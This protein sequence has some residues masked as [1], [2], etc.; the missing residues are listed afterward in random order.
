MAS[1]SVVSFLNRAKAATL[2]ASTEASGYDVENLTE[3][4]LIGLPWRS[5]VTTDSW[6][7]VDLGAAITVD[8][9]SLVG[10]NFTSVK[11]QQ[12]TSDSWGAPAY[13]SGTLTIGR[14]ADRRLYRISH[15]SA[16]LTRRYTR[17]FIPTQA[18]TDG[19]AYF[20]LAG[21]HLGSF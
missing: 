8:R 17:I 4:E 10:C 18:T 13:D 16:S 14:D 9:I 19:A 6:V 12:H 5:T 7:V 15:S 20:E 11:I 2:T 21:V 1:Q 3:P